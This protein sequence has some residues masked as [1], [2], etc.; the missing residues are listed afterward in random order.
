MRVLRVALSLAVAGAVFLA[1]TTTGA[2]VTRSRAPAARHAHGPVPIEFI[3]HNVV[4]VQRLAGEPAMRIDS[5]NNVYVTG[6]IGTQYATSFLWKSED[7]GHSFDLLRAFPPL[8]RPMPSGGSGDA[9]V[10]VVPHKK[11][12]TDD[13]IVWSDM[14]S[15]ASLANAAS[16]DGGNTF[17]QDFW[18]NA[19]DTPGA[20]RQWL[21]WMP[22]PNGPRIYQWFDN[23]ET[24]GN[25][26]IYTDDYG[27]SWTQAATNVD[28]SPSNPGSLA[29]DPVHKKV[30]VAYSDG[31]KAKIAVSGPDAMQFK[32]AV[33]G[34]GVGDVATLFVTVDTDTAGNVYVA[35]ADRGNPG[36][37]KLGGIYM[38]VS[39]DRGKTFRKPIQMNPPGIKTGVFP[40]VVAG[41]PGRAWVTWYGSRKGAPAASNRGPWNVYGAQ[42]LNALSAHPTTRTVKVNDRPVHDNEICLDGIGCT[43]G[44]AEDRN[45]LDD[46]VSQIDTR[47]MLH[48]AYN[49]T[50]DQ[51]TAS[52]DKDAGGA[53][54]IH[55]QQNSG[56]SLYKKVGAVVP[57]P[58]R[59]TRVKASVK[60]GAVH[61]TGRDSLKPGNWVKDQSGD[62]R[63]PRHG[64][65]CPCPRNSSLDLTS[66]WMQD[67]GQNVVAHMRVKNLPP[68]EQVITK[69]GGKSVVYQVVFWV[70]EKVYFAQLELAGAPRAYAGQPGFIPNQAGVAKI[71]TYSEDPSLTVPINYAFNPGKNGQIKLKI[72][73][74]AIGNPKKGQRLY[75]IHPLIQTLEGTPGAETLMDERDGAEARFWNEG[76]PRLPRGRVQLSLDDPSFARPIRAS[77][78]GYPSHNWAGRIGLGRL[79]PG[80]HHVFVRTKVGPFVSRTIEVTFTR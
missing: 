6:P 36:A 26:V 20:D 45:L 14:V 79:S 40:W 75:R 64:A 58:A 12:Q 42:T 48:V 11:G 62:A 39:T 46:F 18:N 73:K 41:D 65:G 35:W 61:I 74:S 55:A 23:Y 71:A 47:G 37:N 50:N 57:R 63:D 51:L 28:G 21:D 13:P 77:L 67:K 25:S 1:P 72:P 43:A 33:A 17:P 31:N 10:V 2:T 49:D 34:V 8:Q 76:E 5:K 52:S 78:V 70:K 80:T 56:P 29:A 68:A 38:A 3:R 24:N 44:Q 27:Q 32:P 15:L 59:P 30:Y 66:A 53:F 69:S 16:F 19:A 9:E 4:D 60:H 7:K 22:G 54:V